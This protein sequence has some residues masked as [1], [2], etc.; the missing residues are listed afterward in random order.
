M[1]AAPP[2]AA[3]VKQ[4]GAFYTPGRIAEFLV[5]WAVRSSNDKVLDPSFGGGVFLRAA[6]ERLLSLGGE[7]DAGVFGVELDAASHEAASSALGR[8]GVSRSNLQ[9]ENFFLA[10]ANLPRVHTVVGN[11]PFV[12]Y[13]QFSGAMRES[14]AAL[15]RREGVKIPELASSWAPFLV[16]SASVLV[17][18][19]RL[20]MVVPM[21]LC[22][23][24]YAI[25]VLAFLARSFRCVQ[26]VSFEER[27]FPDLSQETLL[28]LAE[29]R[30][31]HDGEFRW[32]HLRDLASLD[33]LGAPDNRSIRGRRLDTAAISS[34]RQRLVEEFLPKR[35]RE[36][37]AALRNDPRVR[38]LG[39]IADVG[40]GYVSGANEFFHLVPGLADE[41][42]IPARFLRPAVCRGR[43]L[44]GLRFSAEDW[45]AAHASGDAAYLL[46]ISHREPLPVQI[47]Q[48]IQTGEDRGYHNAYKCRV[49]DPWYVVPHVH[50][51][52]AFLTYMSGHS[53][54]LVVN[55][56]A[57]VA[58]NTLHVIRMWPLMGVSADRLAVGWQ[59]SLTELSCE[60]E[61]HALGGGLLKLEP[62]EAGRVLVA[63][64]ESDDCR[65]LCE[66]L[67]N[68][69]RHAVE[70]AVRQ[71]ADRMI[72][73][74]RL[75]LSD[76]DCSC[77]HD[78]ARTLRARRYRRSKSEPRTFKRGRASDGEG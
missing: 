53:P 55:S 44:C 63:L 49:R 41:L 16:A 36:L 72:L 65:D 74:D 14:A 71:T 20:A 43:A 66:S 54:R 2:N 76:R 12:R 68:V 25:P 61:G 58:P 78:A 26:F 10:L 47:R 29:G 4:L 19:G 73:R 45:K 39:A 28:L 5:Q 70:G 22:H 15:L 75:G 51:A 18:G 38:S 77:L 64:P 9:H 52:D 48:Y 30:G 35:A 50:R 59:T 37:Y 6:A 3:Q 11:P 8:V 34:G 40:I 17:P 33:K 46:S 57:A 27:I 56:A 31:P 67:D 21:E 69:A 13:Q 60:L 1:I 7:P 62:R 23:A 32:K 24:A 42:G